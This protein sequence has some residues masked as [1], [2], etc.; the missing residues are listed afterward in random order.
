MPQSVLLEDLEI[1]QLALEVGEYVWNIVDN[2]S[3]FR[4]KL[5]EDNLSKQQIPL[6]LTFR[7]VMAVISIKIENNFVIIA[8]A[9]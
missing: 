4:K 3:I 9:P 1:Y 8:E 2:G 5:L 7:K 6:Q